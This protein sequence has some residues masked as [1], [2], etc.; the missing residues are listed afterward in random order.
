[1]IDRHRLSTRTAAL[2]AGALLALGAAGCSGD[3][4]DGSDAGSDDSGAPVASSD[5]GASDAGGSDAGASD[6]GGSSDASD[7]GPETDLRTEALP[8]SAAD[9]VAAAQDEVGEGTLHAVEL[10]YDEDDAAWQ[11][12]VKILA[13]TTDHKVVIDA[14][15]GETVADETETTDDQEQA[16][17]LEDPMTYDEALEKATAEVDGELRGWKLEFDDGMT[18]YQFDLAAGGDEQEVTVDADSGAVTVD[19]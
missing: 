3:A 1:M 16:V 6:A 4:Q 8:V 12:D 2:A 19:D 7:L 5:S 11:F 15:S 10:D 13:G 14:V 17:D 9:A 18:Q